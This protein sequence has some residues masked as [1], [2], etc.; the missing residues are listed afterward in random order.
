MV[1]VH[2]PRGAT[3]W[4]ARAPGA[5]GHAPAAMCA[6]RATG[7]TGAL[8]VVRAAAARPGGGPVPV[9]HVDPDGTL[10]VRSADGATDRHH[11]PAPDGRGDWRVRR[12]RPGHPAADVRLATG[13]APAGRPAPPDAGPHDRPV[14][15]PA[16]PALVVGADPLVAELGA[17]HYLRSEASWEEAGRPS[18]RVRLAVRDDR[19][20]VDVAVRLGRTTTFVAPDADNPL[21]NERAAVNGDGV[22]LHLAVAA[23]VR[24]APVGAW[25]LVPV[26]GAT[27]SR[28]CAPR[29]PMRPGH[30]RRRR[31]RCPLGVGGR[32]L[33]AR[34]DDAAG[35]TAGPRRRA[36]PGA[37]LVLDVLVNEMP[38]GRE[39]RRGQ[40]VLSGAGQG[41]GA[42]EFVYLRGDR[43]D[44]A[45]G[46][47]LRVPPAP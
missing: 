25:L 33:R 20:H 7:D 31:P 17:A 2:A 42:G 13:A 18:A 27:P 23:G 45:R 16:A 30:G 14:D 29:P 40:L 12:A 44:P 37:L 41:G 47:R 24:V 32:R 5:P 38:P 34:R 19:L 35:A 36:R 15:A 4:R 10:V 46:V 1:T 11:P 3:L 6:V 43:H 22:Q 28:S 9:A 26:P 8:T 39:R 21:D